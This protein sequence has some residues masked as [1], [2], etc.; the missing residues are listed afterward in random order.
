MKIVYIYKLFLYSLDV[1]FLTL[2]CTLETKHVVLNG[3]N[4]NIILQ[5]GAKTFYIDKLGVGAHIDL[6][7]MTVMKNI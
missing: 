4:K 1:M 3:G 6:L 2:L 5:K 7:A